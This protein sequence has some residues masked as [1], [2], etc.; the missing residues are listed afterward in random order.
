M[1]Q[2]GISVELDS[3][4]TLTTDYVGLLILT[5]KR[6]SNF[7]DSSDNNIKLDF[8]DRNHWHI[9]CTNKRSKTLKER[10][11]NINTHSIHIKD[12]HS[13]IIHSL[14]GGDITY[15]KKDKSSMIL[16]FQ[17][18][19]DISKKLC[20]AQHKLTTLNK[21]IWKKTIQTIYDDYQQPLK[22][23]YVYLANIDVYCSG[24]KL[25]IQNG[26]CKPKIHLSEKSYCNVKGIRH[27]IVEK[28]HT[29]TEYIT[30]DIQLGKDKTDG[31]ILF[32]TN[33]CG[34]S[35]FMKAIGLNIILAQAGF[36]VAASEF[37]YHPYTQIFTRILNNDNIFRSQ[38]SFAV[39]VQELKSIMNRSD[40]NS[41]ILGD[42][43]CSGTE[44]ISAL[45]I[46]TSGL[47]TLCNRRCTFIFTS[48]LHQLTSIPE[49]Q[50]FTNLSIYHLKI[51]Y[52]KETNELIYDRKL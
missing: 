6:L 7:L 21:D 33:A 19:R 2:K 1:F 28:I 43:L 44:S 24:A 38:S 16:D 11:D 3:Y 20:L 4:D 25:S 34:K 42:E 36:Y 45:S 14:K 46:I 5:T 48:H 18:I 49:I 13:N 9:Y 12:E 41:L 29:Q 52:D 30:N 15:R 32:G 39:E 35:T 47:N 8:D 37:I 27:P 17:W 23:F 40:K 31:I 10:F 51:K 22:E 26:Y 50:S